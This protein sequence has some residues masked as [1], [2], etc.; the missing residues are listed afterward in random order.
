LTSTD[1]GRSWREGNPLRPIPYATALPERE[2]V[3][4]P[5][6]SEIQYRYIQGL[7]LYLRSEDAGEKWL[8]PKFRVEGK[9][10]EQLSFHKG[11]NEF[12]TVVF[13]LLTIHP[14]ESRHLYA[15]IDVEPWAAMIWMDGPL[16][17][18]EIPGVYESTDGGDN[19][20]E[21]E[22][23]P[24]GTT[25]LGI[26]PANP[27]L[28]YARGTG[29]VFKSED[30]ARSWSVV[31]ENDLLVKQP[32]TNWDA[33]GKAG[34]SAPRVGFEASEF[35]FDPQ[36][37]RVVFI[38]SNKGFYRSTDGGNTWCLLNLGFDEL[39]SANSLAMNPNRPT[40]IFLGT[41]RGVFYSKD[42]GNHVEKIF[43]KAGDRP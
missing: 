34:E 7:G 1:L 35:V 15:I 38:V 22:G 25:T 19:W 2:I 17:N 37:P 30:G 13:H 8:L 20:K 42:R 23:A 11:A 24:I 36:D 28:F 29:G 40:D 10:L 16:K 14:R 6:S 41:S 33:G 18:I 3:Q 32:L 4:S 39:G 43:P 5:L 26:S 9:S 31:G 21:V 12:Y 27:S